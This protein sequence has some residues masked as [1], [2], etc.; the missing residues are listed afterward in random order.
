MYD[1]T[2]RVRRVKQTALRLI[3]K[4]ERTVLRRLGTL[5]TVLALGLTGALAHFTDGAPG[6][7]VQ[8]AYGATLLADSAGPSASHAGRAPWCHTC[9]F[10]LPEKKSLHYHRDKNGENYAPKIEK[11]SKKTDRPTGRSDETVFTPRPSA[12]AAGS[13]APWA[14]GQ[15]RR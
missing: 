1:T 10:L 4:R 14:A 6:I 5:C 11:I 8:G 7:A 15:S 13:T 12:P 3:Q 2:E 9:P